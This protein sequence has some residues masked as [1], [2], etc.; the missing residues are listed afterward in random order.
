MVG[1]LFKTHKMKVLV[2]FT[3]DWKEANKK[4]GDMMELDGNLASV[5]INDKKVAKKRV[6]KTKDK[7]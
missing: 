6:R 2:E 3:K 7:E 4:K 5:L 1:S